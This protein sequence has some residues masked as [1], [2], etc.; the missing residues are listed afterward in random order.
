LHA[1]IVGAASRQR[2]KP[3]WLLLMVDRAEWKD[4]SVALRAFVASQITLKQKVDGQNDSTFQSAMNLPDS[5]SRRRS[6]A[7]S[8]PQSYPGS[9][10]SISPSRP[11]RDETVEAGQDQQ[12]TYHRLDDVRMMQAKNGAVFLVTSKDHLKLPSGIM[13]MLRNRPVTPPVQ[14]ATQTATASAQ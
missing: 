13:F 6:R 2:D 7:Q 9:D 14:A 1:T 3:S 11:V 8:N 4:H 10:L 12:L 5:L